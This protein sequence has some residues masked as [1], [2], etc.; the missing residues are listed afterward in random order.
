MPWAV[1]AA[2]KARLREI[3]NVAQLRDLPPP[4][5]RGLLY[6]VLFPMLNRLSFVRE[7]G[8]TGLPIMFMRFGAGRAG[9]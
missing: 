8:V 6:G 3:P 4:R 7:M 1:D 5:G 9:A 2:E